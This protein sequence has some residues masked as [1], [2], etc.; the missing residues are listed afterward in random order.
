MDVHD[1]IAEY[2]HIAS[3]TFGSVG[4]IWN[5]HSICILSQPRCGSRFSKLLRVLA[6]VDISYL[7][8][9]L[10]EVLIKKFDEGYPGR[11]LMNFYL[12]LF[13][14]VFHPGKQ[15]LQTSTIILTVIFSLDR[16]IAVFYPYMIYSVEG[17]LS[18]LLRGP[19]RKHMIL[20]LIGVF[21]PSTLYCVFS[22]NKVYTIDT[23]EMDW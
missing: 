14:F 15:I 4:I 17:C 1:H 7:T 12:I 19:K 8:L 9:C 22:S 2:T 11:N 20:Y 6:F 21:I 18:T 13:P 5:L 10:V 23:A 3:I 16:Y